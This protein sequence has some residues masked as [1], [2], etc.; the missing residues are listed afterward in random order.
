[1]DPDRKG[2]EQGMDGGGEPRRGE[3][4]PSVGAVGL[5]RGRRRYSAG[6]KLSMIRAQEESGQEMR[7]FCEARGLST[8]SLCK[9]R[10]QYA[11]EGEAGLASRRNPR[12]QGGRTRRCF[13]PEE[14]LAAVLSYLKSGLTREVF[15][16]R[17]GVSCNALRQW[18]RVHEQGGG[19]ALAGK[20][21]AGGSSG[22]RPASAEQ[23]A[24]PEKR[25]ARRRL[26]S[27]SEQAIVLAKREQPRAGLKRIRD[28]LW[29][30]LGLSVSTGA[31][32]RVLKEHGLHDPAPPRARRRKP[33]V[34]RFERARP[35]QL[36]QSD[37][38]SYVLARPGRRVYLTVFL[39]DH[40]RY[41]VGWR[42]LA[43]QRQEL[44]L[45]ALEE[46]I[47]RYGKPVEVLTDQGPQY[48]SWRGRSAFRKRLDKLGIRQVLARTH[49]P[50]TVG[51][52]ERLWKTI[53]EE[54]WE[55]VRPDDLTEAQRRLSHWI[56]HYNFFRPHQGIGGVVPAD[57]FFGAE[58]ALRQT[59][60]GELAEDEL[61][62]ALGDPAR[63]PV[64]LFGRIGGRSVS[65][66]GEGGQLVLETDGEPVGTVPLAEVGM[67]SPTA[68]QTMEDSDGSG[69]HE[70]QRSGKRER[71]PRRQDGPQG[72][73]TGSQA[74]G[75][76]DDPAHAGAGAGAVGAGQRGAAPSCAPGLRGDPG[77]V[78]G[79]GAAPRDRRA[80]GGDTAAS[81][82]ALPAGDGGYAR[83]TAQAAEEETLDD[84][85]AAAARRGSGQ[86][87]EEGRAAAAGAVAGRGSDRAL[88]R[89][90]GQ[91]GPGVD[92]G[93]PI[94][95]TRPAG[96]QGSAPG[97]ARSSATVGGKKGG[98]RS[99]GRG[100][101]RWVAGWLKRAGSD[102]ESDDASR[103]GSP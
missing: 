90:A 26:S 13:T 63:Q 102:T 49:H 12:N 35:G 92:G 98:E 15:C 50:Q 64:Y 19:K 82:A 76:S 37:I 73:A 36:W 21:W 46:A 52:C 103:A 87:E 71:G 27:A 34:R 47:L 53:G 77:S 70:Q 42:L 54:L 9:W 81:V 60:R 14:R 44:V 31:V 2:S 85:P 16:K 32:R 41:I 65:L 3:P 22:K 72:P 68:E 8:A 7:A 75:V 95:D 58:D 6:E 74:D 83:G 29:R 4:P 99:H 23:A 91:P 55:R 30:F 33:A 1:M 20:V 10:R 84:Q 89:A 69:A 100:L 24:R 79:Q 62:L 61:R 101:G 43:H 57:R 88:A 28:V 86:A 25:P 67:P 11:A 80:S 66:R 39:D 94:A 38:T 97:Q 48:H 59:L 40:S 78:A 18:C 5:S 45:E 51:K 17:W 96:R 93:E 56:A